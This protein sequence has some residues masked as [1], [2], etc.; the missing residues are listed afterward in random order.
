V[1]RPTGPIEEYPW[2]DRLR[3]HVVTP[4]SEPR[5][6][7]YDVE[8]DLA[9]HYRFADVM[10]LALV[11]RLPSD[12][13]FEAFDTAMSFLAPV[14]IT[15]APTHAA[16]LARI[17]GAQSSGVIGTAAVALAERARSIVSNS[18]GLLEWLREP[19]GP[20]PP[21]F[22]AT[23]AQDC[24]AVDRLRT[25]L[26]ARKVHVPQLQHPFTRESALVA[27]LWF[28]GL[29]QPGQLEAAIVVASLPTAVAEAHMHEAASF[30][31]YPMQLPP[32]EYEDP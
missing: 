31:E 5:V 1:S 25:A 12:E 10:L 13:Q 18:A 24:D 19:S 3:A 23:T 7:G 2:P 26:T 32:F 11:G 9:R 29:T 6:H 22:L 28:A 30:R 20:I 4:G 8:R 15:E 27:T 14:P 21:R 16:V 17:C